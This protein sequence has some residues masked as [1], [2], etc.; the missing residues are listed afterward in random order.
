MILFVTGHDPATR[1]NIA[2]ARFLRGATVEI[3]E[4][5][6]IRSTLWKALAV[7]SDVPMF[8]MSHGGRRVLCAQGRALPHA[9]VQGDERDLGPRRVFAWACLTSAELGRAVAEAGGIWIGFPVKIAAPSEEEESQRLL[10]QALQ[11]AV[12]G[13]ARVR[14]ET[15]C[16]ALLDEI[17]EAAERAL[18]I[19]DQN[20]SCDVQCFEQIR[21]RIEAWLP[22][23]TEPVRPS[24]APRNRVDDLDLMHDL[25]DVRDVAR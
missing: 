6:A 19:V 13:L 10:A 16:R 1:A 2:V 21:L 20:T 3:F 14:D 5:N 4:Q 8:A 22:G 7:R 25:G 12:D 24:R 17:V 9:I 23:E 11:V 18:E 15:S